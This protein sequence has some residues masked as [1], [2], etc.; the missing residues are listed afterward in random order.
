MIQ[1]PAYL[2]SHTSFLGVWA[3]Q[4][5]LLSLFS[6]SAFRLN[7]C[8]GLDDIQ[9]LMAVAISDLIIFTS[10]SLASG[11]IVEVYAL[12]FFMYS[13]YSL[14]KNLEESRDFSWQMVL[15]NG[16]FAGII[17][18]MKYSLLGFYFAWAAFICIYL[19]IM[20][21][22]GK[23]FKTGLVFLGG[24]LIVT[25][26]CLLYFFMNGAITDLI[27][28]YFINNISGYGNKITLGGL[29]F[30]YIHTLSFELRCNLPVMFFC[31]SAF[32]RCFFRK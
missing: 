15:L 25:I 26:P 6:I 32:V 2:I 28:Y 11:Q 20:E 13:L 14:T 23:A 31:L 10:R 12:P 29:V 1:I 27:D 5:I 8:L 16:V 22:F 3:I 17:L 30:N 24:M 9:S 4:I 7:I 18:W 19:F 21:S